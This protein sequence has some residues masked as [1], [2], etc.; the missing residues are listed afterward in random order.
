MILSPIASRK[1][2][3]VFVDGTTI[4]IDDINYDLS[5]IPE[6]GEAEAEENGPFVGVV[7]RDKVTVL[8]RYDSEKADAIQ[9]KDKNS[10]TFD[11]T[12]GFVPDPI[13]RKHEG[14]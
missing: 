13:K 11:I 10:F 5:A 6:D 7:K 14:L 1:D 12:K 8:F 3:K 9:L 4:T 2:T